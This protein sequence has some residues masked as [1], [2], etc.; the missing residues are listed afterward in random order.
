MNATC[1]YSAQ[2]PHMD[3]AECILLCQCEVFQQEGMNTNKSLQD[4]CQHKDTTNSYV[5]QAI[6]IQ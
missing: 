4:A 6:S 2:V 3:V 1:T 5:Q